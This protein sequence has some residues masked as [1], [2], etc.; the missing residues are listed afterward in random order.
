MP[1]ARV[2]A[3]EPAQEAEVAAPGPSLEEEPGRHDAE[4]EPDEQ[5]ARAPRALDDAEDV[6]RPGDQDEDGVD[7]PDAVL[8]EEL[9]APGGCWPTTFWT[10]SLS[11]AK[12]QMAHQK[13][14]SSRKK[15][16]ISG[17]QSTQVIAVPKL[18][19]AAA[20]PKSSWKTMTAKTSDRRDLEDARVE[21][22]LDDPAEERVVEQ[23][24]VARLD[25]VGEVG[26]EAR[27]AT[28]DGDG[29][30]EQERRGEDAEDGPV[31]AGGGAG[32]H[33]R[34]DGVR[35]G[36]A[37]LGWRDSAWSGRVIPGVVP[38]LMPASHVVAAAHVA[39]CRHLLLP[40]IERPS[41]GAVGSQS[42]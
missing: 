8:L 32:R 27:P 10:R 22:A 30:P 35:V 20:G 36:P 24:G 14:P 38:M 41:S 7:D 33:A 16:G 4:D 29:G 18:S 40:S 11:V 37:R 26:T 23:V 2:V 21:P 1:R 19:W 13:R 12:G 15:S 5:H 28:A 6:V 31:G 3:R 9:R 39:P 17:H 34:V 25:G 42:P